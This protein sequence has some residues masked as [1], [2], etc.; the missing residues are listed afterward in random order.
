MVADRISY[1]VEKYGLL[2]T[3]RFGPRKQ[4][5]TEQALIVLQEHIYKA[6]RSKKVLSL[7]S[8]DVKRAYNGVYKD[9]LLER[10]IA[11]GIPS[12]LVRWIEAFC[13]QRTATILVNGHTSVQQLLPQAGLPQGS[14]LSTV[15][16]LFFNADLVQHKINNKGGAIA[17]VDDYTAW[18]TGPSA[19]ANR[20]GIEAIIDR[21]I[22]WEKRSGATFESEKT[23]LVY[24]TREASRSD[25]T[26]F[27][28]KDD[29][30]APKGEAKILGVVMDA[31][32]WYKKHI[33]KAATKG[34]AAAMAL[35]RLKMVSPNTARQL[36]ASMVAPVIDYA[37]NVWKH[38]CK[39]E[40]K[41]A[42]DRVQ[43]MG[44]QAVTG[45]FRTVAT[46][47]AEA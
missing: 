39:G 32:L 35:K 45:A 15:L 29:T 27:V 25:N 38:A 37:S 2:P 3:N 7:I 19:S 14:P 18:V 46:V 41:P 47:V 21:A 17:F 10:L 16:F 12:T 11:R 22:E 42:L 23:V 40:A 9:R 31:E 5:S 43:K 24:F 34:L 44:A 33:A 30:V 28:I 6:W 20:A 1:A 36:F 8:F 13:S 4:R 26:P